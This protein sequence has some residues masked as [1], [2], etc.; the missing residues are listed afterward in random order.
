VA[1]FTEKAPVCTRLLRSIEALDLIKVGTMFMHKGAARQLL[2]DE[3]VV[4][5]SRGESRAF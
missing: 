2:R 4:P 5:L 1:R 3:V